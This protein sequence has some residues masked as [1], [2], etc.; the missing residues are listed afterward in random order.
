MGQIAELGQKTFGIDI[1]QWKKK[2]LGHVMHPGIKETRGS[3][4]DVFDH[5]MDAQYA[6]VCKQV[7]KQA[8]ELCEKEDLAAVF[9]VGSNRLV[10]PIQAAF[11]QE[12]RK[13]V[14]LIEEDLGGVFSPGLRRRLEPRIVKWRR[15]REIQLVN[16]LLGS[17]HGAVLGVDETLAQLQN[18]QLS[19]LILARGLEANLRQCTKCALTSRSADPVCPACGGERRS[20][21]LREVLPELAWSYVTKVEVV[22]GEAAKRLGEVGAIGGWLR[23]PTHG[24]LR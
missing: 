19:R 9:L 5:R 11:P 21:T 20:T 4:R 1:S 15:Q 22:T 23:Q 18:E 13:R 12:L 7:A 6:R 10:G 8:K 16:E 14:V 17:E 24:R 3:Q 2:D